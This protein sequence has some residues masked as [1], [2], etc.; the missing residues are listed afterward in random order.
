MSG[1]SRYNPEGNGVLQR[2]AYD[3]KEEQTFTQRSPQSAFLLID[4]L[5]RYTL[6]KEG[7]YDPDPETS[8]NNIY[9]NHQ[10]LNGLGEIRRAGVTEIS[11][12]WRTPNVNKINQGFAVVIAGTEY[13]LIVPEGFYTP[14]ELAA[15]MQAEANSTASNR[16]FHEVT[17]SGINPV[18]SEIGIPWTFTTDSIGR[19]TVTPTGVQINRGAPLASALYPRN[20]NG[21]ISFYPPTTPVSTWTGG[22]PRMS[23][24]KYIDFVSSNLCKHQR[25]KDGLTQLNYTNIICRLYLQN[26]SVNLPLQED[27]VGYFGC[28]PADIY[29]QFTTPKMMQWNKDEMISAVDIK[30][31]DDAGELLYIPEIDWDANYFISMLL[32]ES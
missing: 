30:L 22:I 5:D 14:Q 21:M 13:I 25:L 29:Q 23:F 32:S 9:I 4:S 19:F 12:P 16:G 15:A 7:F 11:F 1:V 6:T 24:T 3:E 18:N 27:G 2:F 20:I 8:P 17:T 31:Y 26:G 10:K 28:R